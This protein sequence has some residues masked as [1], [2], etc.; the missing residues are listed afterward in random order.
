[1]K[2]PADEFDTREFQIADGEIVFD[3]EQEAGEELEVGEET[4]TYCN[5]CTWHGKFNSLK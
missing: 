1:V 3:G 5:V 2:N 4:E